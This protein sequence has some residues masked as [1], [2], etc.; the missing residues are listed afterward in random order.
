MSVD[1]AARVTR[2]NPLVSGTVSVWGRGAGGGAGNKAIVPYL[3]MAKPHGLGAGL[4]LEVA[5]VRR[6]YRA[7][8]RGRGHDPVCCG[9]GGG[10][11]PRGGGWDSRRP[12][13]ARFKVVKATARCTVRPPL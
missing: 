13:S 11:W 2:N 4:V 3:S 8:E 10:G 1:R 9:V 12:L 5:M 7:G 6:A